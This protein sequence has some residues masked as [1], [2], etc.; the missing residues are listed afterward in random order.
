M[1][2]KSLIKENDYTKIKRVWMDLDNNTV[3]FTVAVQEFKDG[4][5][6]LGPFDYV[7]SEDEEVQTFEQENKPV[8]PKYPQV[9]VDRE[10]IFPMWTEKSTQAEKDAYQT[11]KD[12]YEA[13]IAKAESDTSA[14]K[15]QAKTAN[16]FQQF[17]GKK[18]LLEESNVVAQAYLF[19]K[20]LPAFEGAQDV[21][22]NKK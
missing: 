8:L 5:E 20:T 19:L 3:G 2:L 18:K 22:E 14:I 13:D 6:I 17:F 15:I 11:A 10:A 1:A 9:C 4:R 12:K 16:K 21:I 7:I